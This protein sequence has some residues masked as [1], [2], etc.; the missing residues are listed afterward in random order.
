LWRDKGAYNLD[1]RFTYFPKHI[2]SA[3]SCDQ[4]YPSFCRNLDLGDQ[5]LLKAELKRMELATV[6]HPGN[7]KHLGGR[8]RQNCDL[9]AS[10]VYMR[11]LRPSK[12]RKI[13]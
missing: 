13:K 7:P 10:P 4:G 11:N 1:I 2:L 6:T 8:G 9:K 12:E 3:T 5:N